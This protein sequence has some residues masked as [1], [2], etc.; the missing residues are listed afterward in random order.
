MSE[1]TQHVRSR[2]L[3]WLR[4]NPLLG[5]GLGASA[6]L[7]AGITGSGSPQSNELTIVT[8]A[9]QEKYDFPNRASINALELTSQSTQT[10]TDRTSTVSRSKNRIL[11]EIQC[12]NGDVSELQHVPKKNTQQALANIAI[13]CEIASSQV[14][15]KKD[16]EPQISCL[17]ELWDRESGWNEKADNAY[18]SAG[19]IP[20][21]LPMSKMASAGKD[22]KTNPATQIKWGLDYIEARYKNPCGALN[23]HDEKGWY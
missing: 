19:G 16:A 2:A 17:V 13:A 15:F 23:A 21:A 14:W 5:V 18:S 11:P 10:S 9:H 22:W 7:L 20:Q 8:N 6:L 12:W 1:T 4:A 3:N